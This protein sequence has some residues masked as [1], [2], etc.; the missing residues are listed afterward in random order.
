LAREV[1]IS[2]AQA[3]YDPARHPPEDDGTTPS[4]TDA[5]RML[6]SFVAAELRGASDEDARR[7]LR[8]SWR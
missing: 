5:K 2:I 8:A 7:F 3:V 4:D 1:F 6:A